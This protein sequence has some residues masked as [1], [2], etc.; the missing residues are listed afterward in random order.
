MIAICNSLAFANSRDNSDIDFF[1]IGKKHRLWLTRLFA[2]A[3][4]KFLNLR[5]KPNNTKNKICLSF[6]ISEDFLNLEKIA[7]PDDVHFQFW[8]NQIYPFYS[9]AEIYQKF[10]QAN[11]WSKNKLP[12]LSAI[13]PNLRRKIKSVRFNFLNFL[14]QECF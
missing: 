7:Y 8:L 6:F 5:P 9:R 13:L 14:K 10:S 4:I 12:N 3:I 11:E 1:I 2:V